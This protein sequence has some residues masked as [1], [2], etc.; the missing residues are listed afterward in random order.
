MIHACPNDC[1]L[2]RSD[3]Y[4]NLDACSICGAKRYKIRQNNTGDVGGEPAKK[5]FPLKLCG[6]SL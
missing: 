5:K 3:E 2:Y 6:I 4:E 1:I